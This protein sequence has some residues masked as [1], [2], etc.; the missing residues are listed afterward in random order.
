MSK[1]GEEGEAPPQ[2]FDEDSNLLVIEEDSKLGT[3]NTPTLEGLMKK[4][5]KLKAE[6]KKLRA[7]EKKTKVYSSSRED[8]DSEEDV[9]KKG[10]KG[11]LY[12][13]ISMT[14]HK[15]CSAIM[16]TW[17]VSISFTNCHLSHHPTFDK[18]SLYHAT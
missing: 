12:T 8:G 6:N 10:R 18:S 1:G 16:L 4:L 5:E 13:Y 17:K 11:I 2:R 3:P 15:S 7:K 14:H 9:S